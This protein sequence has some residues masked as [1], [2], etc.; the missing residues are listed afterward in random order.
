M[1]LPSWICG[2][3]QSVVVAPSWRRHGI[4]KQLIEHATHW[5]SEPKYIQS[6]LG[7]HT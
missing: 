3:I 7:I 1:R 2:W 5:F 4:A 6:N